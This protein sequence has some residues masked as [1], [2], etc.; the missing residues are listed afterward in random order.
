MPL[1]K[2]LARLLA[3]LPAILL[4]TFI[5]VFICFTVAGTVMLELMATGGGNKHPYVTLG[6]AILVAIG[7]HCWIVF[8]HK[9][10]AYIRQQE[11]GTTDE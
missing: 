4:M 5:N 2:R 3:A 9:L 11:E 6:V 1:H 7:T 10:R 8:N